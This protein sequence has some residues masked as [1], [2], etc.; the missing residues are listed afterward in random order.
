MMRAKAGAFTLIE[1]M[2]VVA[3]LAVLIAILLP[4]LARARQQAMQVKCAANLK[5]LGLGMLHYANDQNGYLP[6]LWRGEGFWAAQLVPYVKIR[7]SKVGSRNGL[8]RCPADEN[9]PY[10]YLTGPQAGQVASE[11]EKITTDSGRGPARST[12][13]RRGGGGGG[14][15]GPLPPSLGPLIEPL[16]YGPSIDNFYVDTGS[17]HY[18]RGVRK[19]ATLDRPYCQILLSE[20]YNYHHYAFD[21]HVWLGG[22]AEFGEPGIDER[23]GWRHYGGTNPNSNGTNWLF[24]DGHVRWH[25]V[26][27]LKQLFCCQDFPR[28]ISLH[29]D[30]MQRCG[31][32]AGSSGRGDG[33]TTR[34][35]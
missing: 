31:G 3:I 24:A 19:L 12:T 9:P 11:G 4:S 32:D 22:H 34:R 18:H 30:Q 26:S 16:T 10:M 2:V 23:E 20:A 27:S 29:E 33:S 5:G 25:S 28:G 8:L 15:A 7:R 13:R 17:G 21:W 1:L 6:E 14:N 35:R